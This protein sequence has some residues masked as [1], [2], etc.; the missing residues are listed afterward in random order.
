M[1][2]SL[3]TARTAR[4]KVDLSV[5][6]DV[7]NRVKELRVE[8]GWTQQ[9][10]ADAVGVSRQS[11]NSIERHR[12][13]P[14]LPLALNFALRVQEADR[15]D[16]RAGETPVRLLS[17]LFDER[18]LAHRLRSTSTAGIAG[19]VMAVLLFEYRYFVNHVASWDLAAIALTF[20]VVKIT[21]MLWY[22]AR[23]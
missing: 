5:A 15:R 11:I 12:Y 10:L 13:V 1:T 22:A 7:T 3:D 16:L 19:A 18:F 4:C 21:L 6:N 9:D 2:S 23:D 8:R 17:R 20:L 14:S